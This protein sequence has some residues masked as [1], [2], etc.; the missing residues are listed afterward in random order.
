MR[1][2]RGWLGRRDRDYGE[3][4]RAHIELEAAENVWPWRSAA[5]KG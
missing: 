5:P 1:R 3:E 2:L 4:I